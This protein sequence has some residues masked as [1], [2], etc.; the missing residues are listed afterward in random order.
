MANILEGC[1]MLKSLDSTPCFQN[2]RCK[3][4]YNFWHKRAELADPEHLQSVAQANADHQES[5]AQVTE[6]PP[7]PVVEEPELGEAEAD[8][9]SNPMGLEDADVAFTNQQPVHLGLLKAA[10]NDHDTK[11][12]SHVS[13]LAVRGPQSHALAASNLIMPCRYSQA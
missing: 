11:Q 1:G 2:F 8:D 3:A 10:V 4:W 7:Q 9:F 12:L 6:G 13:G 5:L